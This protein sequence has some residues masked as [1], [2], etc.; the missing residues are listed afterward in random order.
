MKKSNELP[1]KL[2]KWNEILK[3]G[4]P[5]WYISCGTKQIKRKCPVCKGKGHVILGGKEYDCPECYG[6]GTIIENEPEKW[7]IHPNFC[8]EYWVVTKAEI[9]IT[10]KS[11]EY[12]VM[13]WDKC[14]GFR[15]E[16]V[17]T[18]KIAATKACNRLNK[19]IR[20]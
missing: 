11:E 6:D 3:P 1:K 16:R 20:E 7:R 13:Y 17:F 8:T 19:E 4:T 5:F 9:A 14:N 12:E 2:L 10:N 15:A 18:S